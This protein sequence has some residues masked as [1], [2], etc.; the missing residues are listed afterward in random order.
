[1]GTNMFNMVLNSLKIDKSNKKLLEKKEK[2]CYIATIQNTEMWH[3]E[4]KCG[5]CL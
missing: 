2:Y 3:E 1:M 5:P 4:R